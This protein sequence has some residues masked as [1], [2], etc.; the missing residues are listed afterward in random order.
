MSKIV[1]SLIQQTE[2][3]RIFDS[4][5]NRVFDWINS[6]EVAFISAFRE[7]L[8][9]IQNEDKTDMT[10]GE[11]HKFTLKENLQRSR[12]LKSYLL[13]KGY[14]VTELEGGYDESGK[15][16]VKGEKSFLVVNLKDDP[17]FKDNLFKI[18]E[19]YNQDSFLYKPKDSKEAF[20]VG[21]N[22]RMYGESSSVGE[23]SREP[24]IQGAFSRIKGHRFATKDVQ[25]GMEEVGDSDFY[26]R[27]VDMNEIQDAMVEDHIW[28]HGFAGAM[29]IEKEV[30]RAFPDFILK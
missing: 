28:K 21:T 1:D 4:N 26:R 19:Y 7:T 13:S 24:V 15:G 18:S 9:N 2:D 6:K 30:K 27:N 14:G 10:A 16:R 5:M 22:A 8:S 12:E 25:K 3:F 29:G 20:E 17:N 23:F 11:G